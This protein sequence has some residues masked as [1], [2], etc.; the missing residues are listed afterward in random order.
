MFHYNKLYQ[1][2]KKNSICHFKMINLLNIFFFQAEPTKVVRLRVIGG[3][4]LA[5]KDIFGARYVCH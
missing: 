1:I 4:G 3:S 2:K 5:K